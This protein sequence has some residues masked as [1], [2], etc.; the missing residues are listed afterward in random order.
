MQENKNKIEAILFTTGRFM[1]IEEIAKLCGIGST[2]LVKELIQKLKKEYET[3]NHS[4][5]IEEQN[6]KFKLGLK[7]QY[8]YLT[9]QLLSDSE[10]DSPTTKTLAIIAYKQPILQSEVIKMRGN[11]AYDHIR[12]LKENFLIT[13]EKKGRTRLLKLAPKFYDYFDIIEDQLKSKFVDV[14]ED[15]PQETQEDIEEQKDEN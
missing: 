4:L 8:T 7:K 11:K 2:G 10:L 14:K 15:I 5:L 12:T 1:D 3:N 6:N 13:S 9:T